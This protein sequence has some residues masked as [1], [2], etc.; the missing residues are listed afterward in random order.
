MT[1]VEIFD[2]VYEEV[3]GTLNQNI[4][5]SLVTAREQ[6]S[7]HIGNVVGFACID[8]GVFTGRFRMNIERIIRGRLIRP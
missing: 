2:A 4:Y 1:N 8:S 7:T 3:W 6:Y 5:M